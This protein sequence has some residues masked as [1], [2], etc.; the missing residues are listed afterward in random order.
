MKKEIKECEYNFANCQK[1]GLYQHN[2]VVGDIQLTKTWACANCQ[3]TLA[4]QGEIK[5]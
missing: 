5:N 2:K 1:K 3:K 4:N